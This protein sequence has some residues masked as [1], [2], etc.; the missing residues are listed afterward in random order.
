[1]RKLVLK[2]TVSL[3]GFMESP[4]G[5][6]DW[7]S[8]DETVWAEMFKL[9][10]DVDTVVLGSGMYPG[11]AGHWRRVLAEPGK[12]PTGE[13]EFARWA[14]ATPHVVFSRTLDGTDWANTRV[15]RDAAVEIPRMKREE[16]KNLLVFGGVRFAGSLIEQGLVDEFHLAV[17][18]VLLGGG[19]P[20]FPHAGERRRLRQVNAKALPSGALWLSYRA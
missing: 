18:P 15:M 19:K 13:A 6:P 11:Y 10:A 20:L 4:D 14:D 5:K 16:G 9:F 8:G 3:D 17:E 1:M 2:T 7:F 12:H